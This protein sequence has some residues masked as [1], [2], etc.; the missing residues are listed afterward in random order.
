MIGLM[1]ADLHYRYLNTVRNV[2][3]VALTPLQYALSAPIDALEWLQVSAATQ[4][5]LAKENTQLKQQVLLMQV[6]LQQLINMQEENSQLRALLKSSERIT[7]Q[8][9]EA[10]LLA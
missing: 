3:S 8:F 6:K 10:K 1:V 4:H 7:G 9:Q 5:Q 2:L